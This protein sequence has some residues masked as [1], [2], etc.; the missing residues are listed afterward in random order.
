MLTKINCVVLRSG[1]SYLLG[2]CYSTS[3][4][5]KWNLGLGGVCLCVC[6]CVHACVRLQLYLSNRKWDQVHIQDSIRPLWC[7]YARVFGILK[8]SDFLDILVKKCHFSAYQVYVSHRTSVT[9]HRIIF[10]FGLLLG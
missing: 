10:I 8:K 5:R 6:Q 4:H 2:T 9:V 7:A 3:I 1:I